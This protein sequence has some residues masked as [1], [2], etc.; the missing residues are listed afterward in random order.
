LRN[1]QN[2]V[3]ISAVLLVVF[4]RRIGIHMT[5]HPIG[6]LCKNMTSSTKP[7]VHK[8]PQRRHKDQ[9]RTIGNVHKTRSSADAVGPRDAPQIRNIDDDDDDDG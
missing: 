2:I 8:V 1:E 7:E 3:G 5:S 4:Y 6:T 9:A